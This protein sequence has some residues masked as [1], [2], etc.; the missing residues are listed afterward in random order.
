[1]S[2]ETPLPPTL[3]AF[4]AASASVA[5]PLFLGSGT[6]CLASTWS[7][8]SLLGFLLRLAGPQAAQTCL[9]LPLSLRDNEFVFPSFPLLFLGRR[10][11]PL[12]NCFKAGFRKHLRARL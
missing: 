10:G 1:M 9:F 3:P 4:I 7:P 8:S 11:K 6:F 12:A 5:L 2:L